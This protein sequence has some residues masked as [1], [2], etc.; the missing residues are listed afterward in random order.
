MTDSEVEE[1]MLQKKEEEKAKKKAIFTDTEENNAKA[2]WHEHELYQF[3]RKYNI[4]KTVWNRMLNP[5]NRKL[6]NKTHQKYTNLKREYFIMPETVWRDLAMTKFSIEDFEKMNKK[7]KRVIKYCRGQ[8]LNFSA[9]KRKISL[10]KSNPTTS[11]FDKQYDYVESMLR[12]EPLKGLYYQMRAK[13]YGVATTMSRTEIKKRTKRLKAKINLT[14]EEEIYRALGGPLPY[15]PDFWPDSFLRSNEQYA[16]LRNDTDNLGEYMG[17]D[18]REIKEFRKRKLKKEFQK[19]QERRRG[20]TTIFDLWDGYTGIQKKIWDHYQKIEV[21]KAEAREAKEVALKL[22]EDRMKAHN[23]KKILKDLVR[24][25]NETTKTRQNLNHVSTKKVTR[26]HI[27]ETKEKYYSYKDQSQEKRKKKPKTKRQFRLNDG[28]T[29]PNKISRRERAKRRDK[30]KYGSRYSEEVRYKY[31][32]KPD[33]SRSYSRSGETRERR[34]YESQE[35]NI[36]GRRPTKIYNREFY[37]DGLFKRKHDSREEL[38]EKSSIPDKKVKRKK[39]INKARPER[40]KKK[41]KRSKRD[42]SKVHTTC[43]PIFIESRSEYQ[44]RQIIDPAWVTRRRAYLAEKYAR[45]AREEK[46]RILRKKG[47]L[48]DG[49]TISTKT[50]SDPINAQELEGALLAQGLTKRHKESESYL[51]V[52]E[53]EKQEKMYMKRRSRIKN[54]RSSEATCESSDVHKGTTLYEPDSSY[55]DVEKYRRAESEYIRKQNK[56]ESSSYFTSSYE[57]KSYVT[58][59]NP[60][61]GSMNRM[62]KMEA[63]LIIDHKRKEGYFKNSP[64]PKYSDEDKRL[65]IP[66]WPTKKKNRGVRPQDRKRCSFNPSTTNQYRQVLYIYHKYNQLKAAFDRKE[67]IDEIPSLDSD[68]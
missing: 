34:R 12:K 46:E 63:Q 50:W 8:R 15:D 7:N 30:K 52:E 67:N 37:E 53:Y 61:Y 36:R 3:F 16:Y 32:R 42:I 59:H 29:P 55:I 18:T 58:D 13:K 62:Q 1:Y 33:Y 45:L 47:K 48:K 65:T 51:D 2:M 56:T 11:L 17:K 39:R 20:D 54:E 6:F 26:Y 44:G 68:Y 19:L 23:E 24:A 28:I 57:D 25:L 22:R 21:E 5:E 60:D 14:A 38:K 41:K 27:R 31:R 9:M 10:R 40:F 4:T 64:R 43:D 49:Q 35:K 66:T